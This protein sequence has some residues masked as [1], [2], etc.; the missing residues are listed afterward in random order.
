VLES[1]TGTGAMS[2]SL[3]RAVSPSGHLHT[4]EFNETRATLARWVGGVRLRLVYSV[5]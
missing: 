5:T 2:H 1:G 4:F 3:M